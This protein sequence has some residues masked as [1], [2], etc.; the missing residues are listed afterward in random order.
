MIL[1]L[2]LFCMLLP[3]LP[4]S[5]NCLINGVLDVLRVFLLL[6]SPGFIILSMTVFF[7]LG[8]LQEGFMPP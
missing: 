1:K 5:N 4:S 6:V 2:A 3:N 7:I 8:E